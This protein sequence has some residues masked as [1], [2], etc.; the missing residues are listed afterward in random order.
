MESDKAEIVHWCEVECLK[1]MLLLVVNKT[2]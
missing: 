2:S 1:N